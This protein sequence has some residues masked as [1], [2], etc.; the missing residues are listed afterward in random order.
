MVSMA[1]QS[2]LQARVL[3]RGDYL[4]MDRDGSL[5]T[6]TGPVLRRTR[7]DLASPQLRSHTGLLAIPSIEA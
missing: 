5:T 6:A 4:I 3:T 7:D 1:L 2:H